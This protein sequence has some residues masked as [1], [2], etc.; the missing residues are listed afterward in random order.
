MKSKISRLILAGLL[1]AM[2][3]GCGKGPLDPKNPVKLTLWHTYDQQ[4]KASMDDLI[5]EFN[6]T[7]G[8]RE[9]IIIETGFV[10]VA[11]DLHEKLLTAASGAPGSPKL[12]DIAVVYPRAA[13]TLAEKGLLLDLGEQFSE[14]ELSGYVPAFLEEGK[15][16]GDTLYILP[17]AKSTDVLYVNTTI[18]DRLSKDMGVTLSQLATFEG[19]LDAAEKYYTW[20]DAKT[21][22]IPNDGKAFFYPDE[23]F[24]NAMIGFRQL[25]DDFV[26]DQALNLS[27]T[28]FQK[29][30]DSYYPGAVK[31]YIA[32]FDKYANYLIQ[33][34]EI[35]C[36]TSSSAGVTFYSDTVTYADN[37]K[38]EAV[39]AVLPYP[40]FEGGEKIAMQ[41]GG[42]MCVFKSDA[43]K[44]YAAGVFLKWLTEPEQNL[45]FTSRTGYMPVTGAA[46]EDLMARETASAASDNI[47]KLLKTVIDMQR[48]YT[49]YVPPVFDGFEEL[50]KRYKEDLLK[51]TGDSRR[52]YL[53]L[54]GAAD[55][56]AAYKAVSRGVLERF[57]SGDK[58]R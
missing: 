52:E 7:I 49:L 22:D 20:T 33:T 53:E 47:G 43:K 50:Q 5:D 9:G 32:I 26:T 12:P 10:A 25:E 54:L 42:G 2:L 40:V 55:P 38:E 4:M 16:G 18:F 15:M 13:V 44:E 27:S 3:A 17:I 46:F 34:G 29:I 35:V 23:P 48:D 8:E 36:A 19:I 45:R 58:I 28:F 31:G 37:T 14:M 24:N 56:D 39:L 41:R 21:P 6:G 51:T 57:I 11:S 30:W 1:A